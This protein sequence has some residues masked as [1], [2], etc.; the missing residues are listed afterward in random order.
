MGEDLREQVKSQ[1]ARAA[2]AALSTGE[3]GKASCCEPSSCCGGSPGCSCGTH[4]PEEGSANLAGGSYSAEDLEEL[5][6]AATAA[7]L[8]CGNPMALATLSPGEVVLDLGSG[9]GLDVLL[10]ARR[11][12]P[13]GRAYGLDMTDE[14]LELARKN[15]KEAGVENVVFLKGQI[16]YVPL[17]EDHV[18][19]VISNCVINLSTDKPAVIGEAYRVLKPGGRFALYDVVFLGSKDSLPAE[20]VARKAEMWSGC[21]SGALEKAEYE[22][23]LFTAGFEDVSVEATQVY[24]SELVLGLGGAA[25]VEALRSAPVA[26]AFVRARKPIEDR[27]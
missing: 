25:E 8:G 16:E 18:D 23:L 6:E 1:Y 4:E 19:V 11:V 21:V 27:R 5:P 9:G 2:L 3:G 20:V 13:G 12:S 24:T 15:Q 7:S 17:P 10:S 14:M 26:S 22:E